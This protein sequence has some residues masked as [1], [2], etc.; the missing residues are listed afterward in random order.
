MSLR[1]RR[2][3][4]ALEKEDF[5]KNI[6]GNGVGTTQAEAESHSLKTEHVDKRT[7]FTWENNRGKRFLE[8]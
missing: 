6:H 4:P 8:K 2:L 3:T 5:N 7:K 1:K